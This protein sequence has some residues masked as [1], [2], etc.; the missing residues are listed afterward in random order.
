MITHHL[1]DEYLVEYAAGSLPEAESLVVA[2]HAAMCGECRARVETF[3]SVGAV[4]LEDGDAETVSDEAFEAVMAKIE[5]PETDEEPRRIEFDRSTL[6]IIPPPLRAYLDADLSDLNWKRAGRGI[7][8]ASLKHDGDI[9]ISLLRIRPDQKIPAHT[10]GGEEFTLILDGGYTDGDAH[11]GLGDVSHLDGSV[12]HAPVADPDGPCL[13]L[14]V[15][16]GPARL[17][18]KVGRILNPFIRG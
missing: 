13:C 6:K 10:H 7:Q 5:A 9:R 8:E 4:L 17:T 1:T 16:M 14:T 15:R 18:G 12:D 2:S 11:Y 3:E